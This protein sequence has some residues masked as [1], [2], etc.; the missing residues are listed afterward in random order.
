MTL[1]RKAE[2]ALHAMRE[3]AESA[4]SECGG[5]SVG[6]TGSP[7][8]LTWEP[9]VDAKALAE[10]ALAQAGELTAARDGFRSGRVYCYGCATHDC[11]HAAPPAPG[12]VFAGYSSMGVPE[13]EEFFNYLQS[14][15]D[16]RTEALFSER[17]EI[18]ARVVGRQSLVGAQLATS[19]RNS[20]TYR[21]WGQVVAG[22][23]RVGELR[24]ALTIQAVET[25]DQALRF[26]VLA[27]DVL[28]EH[29]ADTP[30]D[31]RSSF[32]RVHDA[33][34]Q[35]RLQLD[36]LSL[37][38]QS[39]RQKRAP[40]AAREMRE[41]VFG[42]LRHLAH[43]LERKGRQEHRR[44]V[45]AE[46]RGAERPVHVAG[47]DILQATPADFFRDAYRG[48]LVVLGRSGRCHIF[49]EDGRHITTLA[50]GREELDAKLRR[51]R[52]LPLSPAESTAFRA[53]MAT[54]YP[55][56]NGRDQ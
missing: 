40:E 23:L 54:K 49:S 22:Y 15:D 16:N 47:G 12:S 21:L 56:G 46:A 25:A 24:T 27:P 37:R 7:F 6:L 55:P 17:P 39:S 13:W 50:I 9:G 38:W 52:Y 1:H 28:L 19:G 43:S 11:Q 31:R 4:I 2:A 14:L 5:T 51:R 41:A 36:P 18:L 53:L 10:A 44:T 26:Q 33:L 45:H 3:L 20:F 34:H 48:S 30:E 32:L 42:Q 35:A 29:L 8:R